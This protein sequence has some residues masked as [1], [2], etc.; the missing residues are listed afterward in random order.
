MQIFLGEKL[1][2]WLELKSKA[3]CLGVTAYS[4]D[5]AT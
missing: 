4:A 2:F 3:D 1:A 5:F